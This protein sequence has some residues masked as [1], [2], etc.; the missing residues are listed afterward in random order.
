MMCQG[1]AFIYCCLRRA[2]LIEA[3]RTGSCAGALLYRPP[4]CFHILAA[5]LAVTVTGSH[6]AQGRAEALPARA[7]AVQTATPGDAAPAATPATPASAED[8]ELKEAWK[9]NEQA[10]A[11]YYEKLAAKL[12]QKSEG[13]ATSYLVLGVALISLLGALIAARVAYLSFFYN[14]QN[15]LRTNR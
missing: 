8:Y 7:G 10:Q 13:G 3:G 12:D 1:A 2:T 5:I 15:Q 11:I 6:A 4:R 9:R 14:Y